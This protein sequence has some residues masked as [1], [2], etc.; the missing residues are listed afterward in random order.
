V[1]GAIA[2]T[3]L[4]NFAKDKIST[5]LPEL[6]LYALG[7]LFILAVTILPK[8]LAGL[9]GPDHPFKPAK[10]GDIFARWRRSRAAEPTTL[11]PLDAPTAREEETVA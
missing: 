1:I 10:V 5:A 9:F 6:W 11:T 7:L 2:G 3:L 8:G 4:V